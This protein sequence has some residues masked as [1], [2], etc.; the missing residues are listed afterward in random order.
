VTPIDLSTKPGQPQYGSDQLDTCSFKHRFVAC[1][2]LIS[3]AWDFEDAGA[4]IA[5]SD[6]VITT[7][8]ALAHL[9]GGLAAPTWLL[10]KR[11]PD[12][13]WGLDG[14]RSFWYPSLRLFRQTQPG[15]WSGE[16]ARVVAALAD[17]YPC[18]G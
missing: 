9:A 12:W 18:A 14:D 6:L 15:D 13:R 17:Q 11:I 7:D 5:L 2:D 10:L 3:Q 16:I 4:L 1:Q 8:S